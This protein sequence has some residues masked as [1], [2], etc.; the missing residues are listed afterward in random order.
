METFRFERMYDAAKILSRFSFNPKN[1]KTHSP[2]QRASIHESMKAFGW[3][4]N[5]VIINTKTKHLLD[6]HG[7]LKLCSEEEL[8]V[9]VGFVRLPEDEESA[10]IALLDS[11][12]LMS[13]V[14]P[15]A[16]QEL[17][18][19]AY[20]VADKKGLS[21][22][23]QRAVDLYQ[24]AEAIKEGR[25]KNIALIKSNKKRIDDR[26]K[27]KEA[28]MRATKSE[29]VESDTEDSIEITLRRPDAN[30]STSNPWGIPDLVLEQC[31]GSKKAK[32]VRRKGSKSPKS[33]VPLILP[34]DVWVPSQGYFGESDVLCWS[35]RAQLAKL[36]D[37]NDIPSGFLAF[38]THDQRFERLF[39]EA[40]DNLGRIKDWNFLGVMEPDYSVY[41]DWPWVQNLWSI[42]RA[43]WCLAYLQKLGVDVIPRIKRSLTPYVN[44]FEVLPKEQDIDNILIDT[45][46]KNLNTV[47]INGRMAHQT[48]EK[49]WMVD[50][51]INGVNKAHSVLNFKNL[52]VYGE[53]FRKYVHASIPSEINVI[54]L[55]SFINKRRKTK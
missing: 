22:L 45:L 33:R 11:L 9:K 12:A 50:G 37:L 24:R 8:P 25:E 36:Y 4:G 13:K 48:K 53:Q 1:Y 15:E 42:Y 40:V 26:R 29:M 3:V 43:R 44:S 27:E 34:E 2:E 46:P 7:R 21:L 19:E 55:D 31:Y 49:T 39:T 5:P 41:E 23:K 35:A 17:L 32:I 20:N 6:G 30:F 28:K 52:I 14:D 47:S 38:Y 18:K 51:F 16:H 54:W 10:F